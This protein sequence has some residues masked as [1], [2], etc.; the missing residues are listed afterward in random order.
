MT[1]FY[2]PFPIVPKTKR[3]MEREECVATIKTF[4]SGGTPGLARLHQVLPNVFKTYNITM[5]MDQ[6]SI[7][8][9]LKLNACLHGDEATFYLEVDA[10]DIC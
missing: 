6:M 7:L 1:T 2:W 3:Q 8:Q 9:E 5:P 10:D 4:I